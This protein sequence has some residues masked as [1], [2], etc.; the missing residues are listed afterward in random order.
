M[1]VRACVSESYL[2][3]LPTHLEVGLVSAPQSSAVTIIAFMPEVVGI[4]IGSG[5][6]YL[7]SI[8]EAG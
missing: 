7:Y 5:S 6:K 8:A 4:S 2:L 1:C 3:K